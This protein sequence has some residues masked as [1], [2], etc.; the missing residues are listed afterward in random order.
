MEKTVTIDL[1]VKATDKS[2]WRTVIE[3]LE[4]KSNFPVPIENSRVLPDYGDG[5]NM[6]NF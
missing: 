5:Y 1:S 4:L 3:R 6:K 2:G